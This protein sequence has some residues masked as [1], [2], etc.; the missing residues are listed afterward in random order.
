M[1]QCLPWS[2]PLF[3]ATS[4]VI[5]RKFRWI[6]FVVV[7]ISCLFKYQRG[8]NKRKQQNVQTK[9]ATETCRIS[10]HFR[11]YNWSPIFFVIFRT[12]KHC[13]RYRWSQRSGT[14]R[15]RCYT[16]PR[17]PLWN[18]WPKI[19]KLYHHSVQTYLL[20]VTTLCQKIDL[21]TWYTESTVFKIFP[22]T[23][24]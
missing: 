23:V 3:I 14:W 18:Q 20:R 4:I 19:Q 17:N 21:L 15:E 12:C 5:I 1:Y 8:G 6:E 13:L 11:D 10:E 22:L 7:F 9:T 16:N 24:S 2:L